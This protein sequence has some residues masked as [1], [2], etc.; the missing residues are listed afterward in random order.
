[1]R[2][3][4]GGAEDITHGI[5]NDK[6]SL[7]IFAL[8]V[9][10]G[11]VLVDI[12]EGPHLQQEPLVEGGAV[13]TAE[14]HVVHVLCGLDH[15]HVLNF[16]SEMSLLGALHDVLLHIRGN[17]DDVPRRLGLHGDDLELFWPQSR[18]IGLSH[19]E[20]GHLDVIAASTPHSQRHQEGVH[21]PVNCP[22]LILAEDGVVATLQDGQE[23][24]QLR[25][26]VN[27]K[28]I[29]ED[30]L[31]VCHRSLRNGG[32]VICLVRG[33]HWRLSCGYHRSSPPHGEGPAE[34]AAEAAPPAG[35]AA[36]SRSRECS[37][38]PSGHSGHGRRRPTRCR[39]RGRTH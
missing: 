9:L 23:D 12:R 16:L 24:A 25:G 35:S 27:T 38:G 31:D 26:H 11:Q 13:A 10:Q 29:S 2:E 20:P 21:V 28:H 18:S 8:Y 17:E 22:P 15:G 32:A 6:A 3:A 4:P 5:G 34:G 1:M 19:E 39:A 37:S 30:A 36:Q 14:A 33:N 7:R